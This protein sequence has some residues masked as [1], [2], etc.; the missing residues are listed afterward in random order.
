MTLASAV[1]PLAFRQLAL[2]TPRTPHRNACVVGAFPRFLQTR[3]EPRV[4]AKYREKLEL[5]QK[6]SAA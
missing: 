1:R 6:M 3:V 2:N 5:K 4:V